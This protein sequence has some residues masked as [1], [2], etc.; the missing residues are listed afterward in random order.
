MSN[1]KILVSFVGGHDIDSENAAIEQ[2]IKYIK[3]DEVYFFVTKEFED[4]I[5]KITSKFKNILAQK[6]FIYKTEI[7]NPSDQKEI[8]EKIKSYLDYVNLRVNYNKDLGYINLTSGTPDIKCVFS[9]LLALKKLP[10]FTGIYAPNPKY[11]SF[12][13]CDNLDFYKETLSLNILKTFIEKNEYQALYDYI[14][15]DEVKKNI[16]VSDKLVIATDFVKNRFVGNMDEAQKIYDENSFLHDM[17]QFSKPRDLFE[18]AKETF[19][20]VE[21]TVESKDYFQSTL[22]LGVIRENLLKYINGKLLN[23]YEQVANLSSDKNKENV[24]YWDMDKLKKNEPNLK[25][26]LEKEQ[27]ALKDNKVYDFKREINTHTD[28]LILKYMEKEKYLKNKTLAKICKHFNCL[29]QLVKQRNSLAHTLGNGNIHS[30][31]WL[32]DIKKIIELTSEHFEI[33]YNSENVY[34]EMNRILLKLL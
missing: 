27:A 29:Q 19:Y 34:D 18:K 6:P 24:Y 9:I 31:N 30:T 14:C 10:R 7:D 28:E 20:S 33:P 32:K 23:G 4:K 2:I 3:P 5:P 25:D 11:D 8:Y 15:L 22:K 16:T 17:F 1:K 21:K 13:R 26:F 12:V